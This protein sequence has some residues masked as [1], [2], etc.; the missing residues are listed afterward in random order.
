VSTTFS[1]NAGLANLLQ[2]LTN[3]GSPLASSP[4]VLAALQKASPGDIVQLSDEATQLE[5]VNAI[6]G[7]P[8][9]TSGSSTTDSLFS[10]L[11]GGSTSLYGG[12]TNSTDPLLESLD[13]TLADPSTSSSDTA[14]APL[15]QD[16]SNLGLSS[17]VDTAAL[18]NASP[19]DIVQLSNEAIQSAGLNQILGQ[20][21]TTGTLGSPQ[22]LLSGLY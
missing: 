18:Q 5:D 10:S 1:I 12:T 4:T 2:N 7:D 6:F 19:T 8:S 22:S 13:P 21:T 15:L 20:P 3:I 16:L 9:T 17:Q 11:Y 14:V